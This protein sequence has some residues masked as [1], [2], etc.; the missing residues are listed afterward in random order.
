MHTVYSTRSQIQEKMF[1]SEVSKSVVIEN[2]LLVL[3]VMMF[4][5]C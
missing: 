2:C 5:V 3:A 1:H 4:L